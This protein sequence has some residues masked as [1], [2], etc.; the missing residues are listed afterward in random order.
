MIVT[1][2][3]DNSTVPKAPKKPK[4]RL[5]K[6]SPAT[7]TTS[8]IKKVTPNKKLKNTPKGG[9]PTAT[10]IQLPSAAPSVLTQQPQPY[11]IITNPPC[12]NFVQLARPTTSTGT[13]LLL[14]TKTDS[15]I[16]SVLFTVVTNTTSLTTPRVTAVIEPT[17]ASTNLSKPQNALLLSNPP[18]FSLLPQIPT[19][20]QFRTVLA[21]A[22]SV[23]I[24]NPQTPLLATKTPKP[25]SASCPKTTQIPTTPAT[26]SKSPA[27]PKV[28]RPPVTIRPKR[29]LTKTVHA[30]K[31]PI[32]ALTSRY[33]NI[34]LIHSNSVSVAQDKKVAKKVVKTSV[35]KE[36]L[37]TGNEAGKRA[38]GT[39]DVPSAKKAKV[40]SLEKHTSTPKG[41]GIEENSAQTTN[42]PETSLEKDP[43]STNNSDAASASATVSR[44][45]TIPAPIKERKP[46]IPALIEK[47]AI[48]PTSI[49]GNPVPIGDQPQPV[50]T[51]IDNAVVGT[52][53]KPGGVQE[54]SPTP[55]ATNLIE[56]PAISTSRTLP[57]ASL[58][59]PVTADAAAFPSL[60]FSDVSAA[61]SSSIKR[62]AE[63]IIRSRS[64][65]EVISCSAKA[66]NQPNKASVVSKADSEKG[67][68][69]NVGPGAF[70]EGNHGSGL[71]VTKHVDLV[72][73]IGA[74]DKH[75]EL[76]IALNHS[77]LSND[78][79][80]SL[81][82]PIGSQNPESTSPTAAFLLAFPLV[83]TL[84]GVKVTEV[85]EDDNLDSRHGTPTLLQIGTME[86]S[87]TTQTIPSDSLTPSLLNLDSSFSFFSGKDLYSS[88]DHLPPCPT[89]S[90]P[91]HLPSSST[92]SGGL[93]LAVTTSDF[94]VK[95][96]ICGN[97]PN[98]SKDTKPVYN[99]AAK[100]GVEKQ[101][102]Q[103]SRTCQPQLTCKTNAPLKV[104]A[105]VYS[106]YQPFPAASESSQYPVKQKI[107]S[108]SFQNPTYD[109]SA[110]TSYVTTQYSLV[111][112][113]PPSVSHC[114]TFNPFADFS[115]PNTIHSHV[116]SRSYP[117]PLYTNSTNYNYNQ[118][119]GGDNL[120]QNYPRYN[121][122]KAA[123]T[124]MQFSTNY[125]MDCSG[126]GGDGRKREQGNH[127]RNICSSSNY[128]NQHQQPKTGAKEKFI[129]HS[130]K[131]VAKPGGVQTKPPIN[132]MTTPDL[133]QQQPANTDFLLPD[134]SSNVFYPTN[135]FNTTKNYFNA[136]A[137]AYPMGGDFTE[138]RPSVQKG[139]DENQFSW[140]PTK[141]PQ[142]IEAPHTF[143]P[144]TLPT[145]VGDLALGTAVP[146]QPFVDNKIETPIIPPDKEH[147]K[148]KEANRR[149]KVPFDG[150]QNNFLSVS[151]LV[152]NKP[153]GMP[154][155]AANRRNSGSRSSKNVTPK[156]SKRPSKQNEVKEQV[157]QN[158]S[159]P[160]LEL[161]KQVPN[162]PPAA[163]YPVQ[164]T[165][166]SWLGECSKQ[167]PRHV[168]KNNYSAE[169]LIGHPTS[170]DTSSIQKHSNRY[171]QQTT[172]Y[173]IPTG[174]AAATSKPIPPVAS[175]LS[176]NIVSYFPTV[177]I[178]Q[179]N[180]VQSNQGYQNVSVQ[181]TMNCYST[182]V[183]TITSTYIPPSNFMPDFALHEYGASSV[184]TDNSIR[185][186]TKSLARN[187]SNQKPQVPIV[188]M[189]PSIDCSLINPTA[190]AK[191]SRNKP[192][193]EPNLGLVDFGFLGM[194][195]AISSPIL[196]DDFH[197]HSNFLPAPA[198]TQLYPCKNPLYPKQSSDLN[199]SALLPL[200]PVPTVCRSATQ[201][202]EAATPTV[203]NMGSSSLTSFNL[204]AI[205]PEINK[206][207]F[208]RRL[209]K[210]A[211]LVNSV[212]F[213]E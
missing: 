135:S 3:N 86:P 170:S 146:H 173:P 151:Q 48:I 107:V 85:I 41:P 22:P 67:A 144:S 30:N 183:P 137:S 14:T 63:A 55:K 116:V 138:N 33:S 176:D 194:S 177:E 165:M 38:S 209:W 134:Y 25:S 26:T 195:G 4:P 64:E 109:F 87:K 196:P 131:V 99:T 12:N 174:A 5:K 161:G 129:P 136:N 89:I 121:T 158:Y 191:K 72:A 60:Q 108:S 141:L 77:E 105:P 32:P 117:D 1:E 56:R 166:A 190:V 171:R 213:L 16:K 160:K 180:F 140:S 119:Q 211:R 201:H 51:S 210:W 208:H 88:F 2:E 45:P 115:K 36:S 193:N 203:S 52:T 82:V 106:N 207:S 118:Q 92:S 13:Y 147:L 154:A 150:N 186:T 83:S 6:S 103:Y 149:S 120:A 130:P 40:C 43:A 84:T 53:S 18:P 156:S 9:S 197:T 126:V 192:G 21:N 17:A 76:G 202:F 62:C 164:N 8:S 23:L 167:T 152:E 57:P 46:T 157:D 90:Q 153:S 11:Y 175:F 31:V 20:L 78:I 39:D 47:P 187:P 24:N 66:E 200:P 10:C 142:F 206:V 75:L 7:T 112:T 111:T 42:R 100:S 79:F 35:A 15:P 61:L 184:V 65:L 182:A 95:T 27:K 168:Q 69:K 212:C 122:T 93:Q 169:A 54:T 127:N 29:G 68:V 189:Q 198:P 58:A 123:P 98:L 80:S 162:A 91:V 94:S 104:V 19:V 50:P 145:L 70:G 74:D 81:Q 204:S 178:S 181:N 163:G 128:Y 139:D 148:P 159:V 102:H 34:A 114:N 101:A 133:K 97:P 110:S 28:A 49:V 132:W 143:V 125:N 179:D 205:F 71:A 37:E 124:A 199:S 113:R 188:N 44:D 59:K 73:D 172:N 185:T 155:R 96:A